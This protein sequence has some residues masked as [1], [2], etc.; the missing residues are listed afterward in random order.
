[1]PAMVNGTT[2]G[3]SASR[4]RDDGG[5]H[6]AVSLLLVRATRSGRSLTNDEQLRVRRHVAAGFDATA[7][8]R[9]GQRLIGQSW[10][11]HVF[12]P[13]DRAPNEIVHFLRHRHEWPSGT[14]LGDYRH[15]LAEAILDPRGGI[16]VE[17]VGQTWR[18]AFIA[19]SGQWRGADGGDWILVGY[20]I[21]YGYWTT[22]YQL[23]LS[24]G[25]LLEQR[26]ETERS[27]WLQRPSELK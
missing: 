9:V 4:E 18:L 11:G 8:A 6:R 1:M 17:Q 12:G 2:G 15:S 22:G 25:E 27:R 21:N 16:Q 13:G 7:T 14:T 5:E 26:P 24:R 19:P 23:P 20:T 10:Q 3:E